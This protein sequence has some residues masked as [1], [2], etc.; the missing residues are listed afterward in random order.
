[1]KHRWPEKS[2]INS[3]LLLFVL[4]SHPPSPILLAPYNLSQ[5]GTIPRSWPTRLMDY[6]LLL[7]RTTEQGRALVTIGKLRKRH[8]LLQKRRSTGYSLHIDTVHFML[9]SF[10]AASNAERMTECMLSEYSYNI[11]F[12]SQKVSARTQ[13]EVIHYVILNEC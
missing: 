13:L 3:F 12:K 10:V 2:T 1:M 6:C 4:C 5:C 11:T 7:E 8:L 9:S